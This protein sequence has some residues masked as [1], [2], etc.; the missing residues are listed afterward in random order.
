MKC[1]NQSINR[2]QQSES[3]LGRAEY[4]KQAAALLATLPTHGALDGVG[5]GVGGDVGRCVGVV[6]LWVVG[7]TRPAPRLAQVYEGHVLWDGEAR[8]V[9]VYH[10]LAVLCVGIGG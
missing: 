3:H 9:A 8:L 7:H 2:R 6:G 10:Q 4:A 5:G 1:I